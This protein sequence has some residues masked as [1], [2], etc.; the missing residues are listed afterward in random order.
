M[1]GGLSEVNGLAKFSPAGIVLEF[2]SKL[3]GIISDGVK[4][5][6]I[7]IEDILDIKFK[8]G[9]LVVP[10]RVEVRPRSL[11]AFNGV[12]HKDGKLTLRIAAR[13]A[14]QAQMAVVQMQR[15]MQ[16]EA[17]QMPEPPSLFDASEDDTKPL[18]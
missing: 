18:S 10:A 5:K 4:E 12:P 3:F 14:E 16:S 1:N 17:P 7:S 11:I 8:R 6:G 9:F 2:E 15:D 13:D